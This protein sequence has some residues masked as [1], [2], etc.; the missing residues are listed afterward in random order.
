M[1]EKQ[2]LQGEHIGLAILRITLGVILLVTWQQN[3][4][5]GF[6]TA[7]GLTG[8][9]ENGIFAEAGI[10]GG[11]EW[12]RALIRATVLAVPGLFA[13]FQLVGELLMGIGLLVGGLTR[14]FAV[15]AVFFF[16]N[17]FLAYFGG[18]EWIWTYVLLTASA[19][20]VALPH[21]GR[22]LG[23]DVWLHRRFGDPPFDF[24]W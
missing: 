21:A 11:P 9:F 5:N 17:L 4:A 15:G 3:L 6:Y 16:F 22:T 24:L 19:L 23:V 8:F 14:L 7:D 20:A 2:G 13:G 18:H 1:N 10:N 12:Y